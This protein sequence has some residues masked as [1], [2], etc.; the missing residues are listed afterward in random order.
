LDTQGVDTKLKTADTLSWHGSEV[1]HVADSRALDGSVRIALSAASVLRLRPDE[2]EAV[3]GF[4]KPLEVVLTQARVE[5]ALDEAVG[6]LAGAELHVGATSASLGSR[7]LPLPWRTEL[8]VQLTLQFRHGGT[9][10][11]WAAGAFCEPGP[12][13]RFI[14][15]YAC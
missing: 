9:L 13:A 1:R 10:T 4:L 7:T 15:S 14:E 8:P 2:P 11:V 5:G 6:N 12:D 3:W